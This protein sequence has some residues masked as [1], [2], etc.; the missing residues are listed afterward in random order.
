MRRTISLLAILAL[1]SCNKQKDDSQPPITDPP[2]NKMSPVVTIRV[3]PAPTTAIPEWQPPPVEPTSD[4]AGDPNVD[5]IHVWFTLEG[6]APNRV[7]VLGHATHECCRE[8]SGAFAD[9]QWE[10]GFRRRAWFSYGVGDFDAHGDGSSQERLAELRRQLGALA[11]DDVCRGQLIVHDLRED[12]IAEASTDIA[13]VSQLAYQAAVNEGRPLML[14]YELPSDVPAFVPP[15]A[16]KTGETTPTPVEFPVSKEDLQFPPDALANVSLDG[17]GQLVSDFRND[18]ETREYLLAL[19]RVLETAGEDIYSYKKVETTFHDARNQAPSLGK[20]L[21]DSIA[22]FDRVY[23]FHT[24]ASELVEHDSPRL[25]K[26]ILEM[27]NDYLDAYQTAIKSLATWQSLPSSEGMVTHTIE[28]PRLIEPQIASEILAQLPTEARLRRELDISKENLQWARSLK[29]SPPPDPG[30]PL[31]D[32]AIRGWPATF[33]SE[34]AEHSF[35]EWAQE[36]QTA[37]LRSVDSRLDVAGY[38]FDLDAIL[39]YRILFRPTP[40]PQGGYAVAPFYALNDGFYIVADPNTG[41]VRF[42]SPNS[43]ENLYHAAE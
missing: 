8:V 28:L 34:S 19:R 14:W 42:E 43:D 12:L 18:V 24:W 30:V 17:V 35:D 32:A 26:D 2:D 27:R 13:Q 23:R 15:L 22:Q 25:S 21:E 5:P 41:L 38:A 10:P 39:G 7:Y 40:T 11:T 36:R 9:V 31:V 16:V 6:G 33:G 3:S 20:K 1:T 37:L 29:S 4:G